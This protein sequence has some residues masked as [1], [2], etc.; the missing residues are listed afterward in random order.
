MLTSLILI[1]IVMGDLTF[2]D[3]RFIETIKS[4][5][6][7]VSGIILAMMEFTKLGWI[8][9]HVILEM[10][11]RH[12][13]CLSIDIDTYERT[14]RPWPLMTDSQ[15]QQPEEATAPGLQ[16]STDEGYEVVSDVPVARCRPR[17]RPAVRQVRFE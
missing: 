6:L 15:Q 17:A 5:L 8:H 16:P 3:K 11:L 9:L 4:L 12:V 14:R 13:N 7:A 1:K 10:I 2:L